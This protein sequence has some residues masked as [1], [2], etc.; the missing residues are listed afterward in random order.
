MQETAPVQTWEPLLAALYSAEIDKATEET[1]TLYKH[2]MNND[3]EYEYHCTD[4]KVLLKHVETEEM[5]SG[6][7]NQYGN[8]AR[9]FNLTQKVINRRTTLPLP[10]TETWINATDQDPDLQLLKRALTEK[11]TPLKASFSC[12][13]YHEELIDNK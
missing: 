5:L 2:E 8:D 12:K 10:T 13:K 4:A 11:F 7:N 9:V 1:A 6:K 3:E